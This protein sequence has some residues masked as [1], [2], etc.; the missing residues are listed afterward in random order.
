VNEDPQG[1]G[2][3]ERAPGTGHDGVDA[4]LARLDGLEERPVAEHVAVFEQAHDDLRAA[5]TEARQT[6]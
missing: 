5:L 4:V 3:E 1:P 6:A 2:P